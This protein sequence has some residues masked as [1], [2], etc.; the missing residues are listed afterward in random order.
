MVRE[1]Q[2]GLLELIRSQ[3]AKRRSAARFLSFGV[4]GV[5]EPLA[6]PA[7][8]TFLAGAVDLVARPTDGSL[9]AEFTYKA[10]SPYMIGILKVG[11]NC[12]SAQPAVVG[13]G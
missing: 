8:T 13:Q 7:G 11:P 4:N 5:C 2:H 6:G 1:W 3:G 9:F 10:S 12:E